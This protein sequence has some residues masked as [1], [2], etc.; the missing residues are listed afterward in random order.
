MEESC[1]HPTAEH[2]MVPFGKRPCKVGTHGPKGQSKSK[3]LTMILLDKAPLMEENRCV[4][5]L[6][7]GGSRDLGTQFISSTTWFKYSL[8]FLT[9]AA[10]AV[11]E[12]DDLEVKEAVSYEGLFF[13][14]KRNLNISSRDMWSGWPYFMYHSSAAT[15]MSAMRVICFRKTSVL[16]RWVH[17]CTFSGSGCKG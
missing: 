3:E 12:H 7:V 16:Q 1:S 2:Y 15:A 5:V 4:Y 11:S 14:R 10:N 8:T 13:I 17:D 6:C 9:D